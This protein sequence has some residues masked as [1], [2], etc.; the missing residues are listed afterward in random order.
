M[1]GLD[2]VAG[3]D[4]A[5]R[6]V[7]R[8]RLLAERLMFMAQRMP[9]LMRWHF[10]LLADDLFRQG[11]VSGLLTQTAQL[12][13]SAERI[14]RAVESV[15]VTVAELPDRIS[16]ERQA[17]LEAIDD[18]EETL[19]ELVHAFGL[20]LAAGERMSASL[21][22][23][24]GTFDAI[25]ERFDRDAPVAASEPAEPRGEPFRILDYAQTASRL[26]AAARE[27]TLMLQTFDQTLASTNLAGFPTQVGVAV[28]QA[29][30]G[31]REMVDY[32]FWRGLF[33]I[34]AV[35]LAAL[36]YRWVAGRL[37]LARR[38]GLP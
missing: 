9:F 7:T 35:L 2:P 38:S 34:V 36:I 16:T 12:A 13:D 3:L 11:N 25:M 27:L 28:E 4:P 14:S 5:V 18:N 29:R 22:T 33:L 21:N 37:T 15:S 31:G 26:E 10:E 23:T 8:T 17:I 6:E 24:L 32:A 20:T 19:R 1:V 30:A